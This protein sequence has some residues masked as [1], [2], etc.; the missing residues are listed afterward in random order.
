MS[1]IYGLFMII[2]FSS[3]FIHLSILS[4]HFLFCCLD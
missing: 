3:T 1:N 4:R 2:E